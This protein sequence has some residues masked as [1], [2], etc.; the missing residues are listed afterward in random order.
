ML[1][2]VGNYKLDLWYSLVQPCNEYHHFSSGIL[3]LKQDTSHEHHNIQYI[4]KPKV[5]L[6]K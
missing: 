3:L 4:S 6:F 2:A 1:K 5:Y